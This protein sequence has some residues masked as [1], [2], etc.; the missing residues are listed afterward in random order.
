MPLAATFWMA[1]LNC[2]SFWAQSLFGGVIE[3]YRA[4]GGMSSPA[5]EDGLDAGIGILQIGGS[6]LP[7]KANM[8]SQS[9]M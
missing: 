3:L 5:A 8:L 7:S 2:T 9:K 6:V 4:R 1:S